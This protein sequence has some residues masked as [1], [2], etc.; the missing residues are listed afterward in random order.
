MA[1]PSAADSAPVK[2]AKQRDSKHPDLA[3]ASD[4]S[5]Y[6]DL[7]PPDKVTY[8]Q[9]K[10]ALAQAD[11]AFQE[12][13]RAAEVEAGRPQRDFEKARDAYRA[14]LARLDGADGL[15]AEAQK[16]LESLKKLAGELKASD[17]ADPGIADAATRHVAELQGAVDAYKASA[18]A[19]TAQ[20]Q[21]V[22]EASIGLQKVSDPKDFDPDDPRPS[23]AAIN[24][25]TEQLKLTLAQAQ[26]PLD[27]AWDAF[28]LKKAELEGHL[29]PRHP[30]RSVN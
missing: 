26:I 22:R 1:T 19:V 27:A 30:G 25:A 18:A 21:A 14:A 17:L 16:K 6:K 11:A 12:A 10:L 9:A 5:W 2:A 7:S 4:P 23:E 24:L 3:E 20:M 28:H 13:M 15:V 29:S 8:R